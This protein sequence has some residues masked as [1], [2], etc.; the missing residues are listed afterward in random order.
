MVDNKYSKVNFNLK[1][2]YERLSKVLIMGSKSC[3]SRALAMSTGV[4]LSILVTCGT[5]VLLVTESCYTGVLVIPEYLWYRSSV[6]T[7][8]QRLITD[9]CYAGALTIGNGSLIYRNISFGYQRSVTPDCYKRVPESCYSAQSTSDGYL[10][11]W[12]VCYGCLAFV[13]P[14]YVFAFL[15]ESSHPC[16]GVLAIKLEYQLWIHVSFNRSYC[17]GHWNLCQ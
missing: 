6:I 11:H 9:S 1:Y 7:G 12:N 3:Y 10:I 16:R 8:D 13:T 17:D 14:T 4:L 15:A 5:G 2:S